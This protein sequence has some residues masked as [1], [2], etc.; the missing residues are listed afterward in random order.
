[1]ETMNAGRERDN[2]KYARLLSHA[3]P[4]PITTEAEYAR[5]L[6][7]V[8]Q[9]MKKGERGLSPEEGRLLELLTVLI[10][11]YEE[12]R[13]PVDK[14]SPLEMLKHL[15]EVHDLTLKDVWPLFSSKGVTSEVL[16]GKRGIS[17]AIAKKLG[18]YF[19]VS[20]ALFI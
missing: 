14:V 17:K 9:L 18:D 13:Y 4:A 7:H 11:R 10:E 16:N 8:E 20:P 19:H 3:L 12:Q 1:M 2:K 5:Q 6:E 15:M